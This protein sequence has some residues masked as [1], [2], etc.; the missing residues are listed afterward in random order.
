MTSTSG[1]RERSVTDDSKIELGPM[2]SSRPGDA[3]DS[4]NARL[5]DDEGGSARPSVLHNVRE[6][7]AKSTAMAA[8]LSYCAA[9]ISMTV[10]NKFAV[11][12][13]KFTMNLLVLLCQCVVGVAMVWTAKLLGWV[14][15]RELNMHDVKTWFPISTMLVFV[16]YT[17]S[18]ALVR[19]RT[20]H[21]NTW[22]SPSTQSLRISPSSSS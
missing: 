20:D 21:S 2:G 22:T 14:Q 10:I 17:G 8:V 7:A 3:S 9:S 16:I 5:L 12:G 6:A 18:K 19:R 11:S 13:E 15:L 4:A 1:S